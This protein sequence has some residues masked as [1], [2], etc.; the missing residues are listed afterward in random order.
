[1]SNNLTL[2]MFMYTNM[3]KNAKLSKKGKNVIK[4]KQ[5]ED[6]IIVKRYKKNNPV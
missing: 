1:M 3:I 4:Y 6:S 5:Q 2:V